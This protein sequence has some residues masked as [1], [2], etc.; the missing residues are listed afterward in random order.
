MR[1]VRLGRWRIGLGIGI[2][3][4]FAVVSR[5]VQRG[6]GRQER[7]DR[8]EVKEEKCYRVQL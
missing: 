7:F 6:R 1:A 3:E 2:L 4:N 5:T 8:E